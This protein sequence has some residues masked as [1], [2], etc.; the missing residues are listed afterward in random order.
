MKYVIVRCEDYAPGGEQTATLLGGA[1]T[2]HL[3]HLAQ[4]GAAGTIRSRGDQTVIDRVLLHRAL[5]GLG[6]RDPEASPG[7]CYAAGANLQLAEGDTSWCCEFITQQDGRII[8]PTA[9]GITTKESEMLVRVLDDQ[10]GSK[11]RRWSVGYGSHHV[12]VTRDPALGSDGQVPV[13]APELLVGQAWSRHLPKG[14]AGEALRSLIEQ[15]STLLE[16]HP[17]NRVRVDLG[18]NPANMLW[19]WGAADA[20]PQRTFAER[21]GLSGAV[22]STSFL[23]HGFA[24]SLGLGWKDG[25]RSLEESALQRL[26]KTVAPLVERHDLVYVHLSIETADPVERLCAMERIDH[27]LLKPLTEALPT[28]GPWR[29]LTAIDD[30]T[31]GSVPIVAIGTGLPQQPIAALTTQTF[32]ESPLTFQ[33]GSGVFSW[34]TRT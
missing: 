12:L 17:V 28:Q 30:R 24:R 9:G 1:K 11:T 22:V 27:L 20:G 26:M 19:L 32:A 14:A 7:R 4:A 6:P 25:P 13:P 31:N 15:A 5:F 18:E 2:S 8:D 34:L 3:Q 29:L 16:H 33:E 23:L 10:L 21:T